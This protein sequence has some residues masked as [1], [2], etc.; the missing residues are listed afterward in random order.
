MERD[1]ASVL[2]I[3]IACRKLSNMVAGRTEDELES[4][5]M[6]RFAVLHLI[7]M[8]GEATYRLSDEFRDAHSDIP[9]GDIMGIRNRVI[10]GYD[11]IKVPIVW[12]VATEKSALLME[13]LEPLLPPRPPEASP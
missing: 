13:R 8:I 11:Q 3:V 9:W 6:L 7:V 2:D 12:V 5:E 4:N 1:P 10:H